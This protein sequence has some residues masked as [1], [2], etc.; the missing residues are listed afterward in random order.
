LPE[1]KLFDICLFKGAPLALSN[2]STFCC[3]YRRVQRYAKGRYIGQ[4]DPDNISC[5]EVAVPENIIAVNRIQQAT[6]NNSYYKRPLNIFIGH[7][8]IFNV[9]VICMAAIVDRL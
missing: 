2:L 6:Y 5:G 1:S 9:R 7:T 8:N 3:F 4:H